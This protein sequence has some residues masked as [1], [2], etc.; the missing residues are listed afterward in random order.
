[1]CFVLFLSTLAIAAGTVGAGQEAPPPGG[2]EGI[3]DELEINTTTIFGGGNYVKLKNNANTAWIAVIYGT[4]DQ[5]NSVILVSVFERYLG[6]A[7]VYDE[8]GALVS[9]N[10][11]I[12]VKTVFAMKFEDIYE[13]NDTNQNGLCNVRV[14]KNGGAI[15]PGQVLEHEPVYKKV[16][17]TTAWELSNITMTQTGE[18][19]K[20]WEFA[21]T[22]RDLEYIIVGDP[23][24]ITANGTLDE[25]TLTFH[26]DAQWGEVTKSDVPVY[27]VGVKLNASGVQEVIESE[28]LEDREY[29]GIAVTADFKIDHYISGWDYD[30]TNANPGLIMEIHALF[31]NAIS[32]LVAEWISLQFLRDINADGKV[33]FERADG[34]KEIIGERDLK[35][36]PPIT[37]PGEQP[38]LVRRN[39]LNFADNWQY[40][41]RLTWESNVT[42]DGVEE[43]MYFQ[44]HGGRRLQLDLSILGRDWKFRGFLI[45]GGFSYPGGET[46]YH[47]PSYVVT[48]LELDV[49][50]E[51]IEEPEVKKEEKVIFIPALDIVAFLAAI[52]ISA[53]AIGAGTI[54]RRRSG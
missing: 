30:P 10:H 12:P 35:E 6:T 1:M 44:V 15:T 39:R 50:A 11:P 19:S 45:M 17:L 13:F 34:A 14:P 5:P 18:N 38:R 43:Q 31:G 28:Y 40:I 27:K 3:E 9:R 54:S 32:P 16:S 25:V 37:D 33:E 21:L 41:G 2:A 48:A 49:E 51:L 42:V 47:D 8:H 52:S 4:E 53:V 22:A 46:I 29:T 36:A 20:S 24:K 7:D 23:E 26:L